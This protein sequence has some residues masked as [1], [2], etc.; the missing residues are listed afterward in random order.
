MAHS[1][2]P[3]RAKILE[4]L[5]E[6]RNEQG[7][8][9]FLQIPKVCKRCCQ[10]PYFKVKLLQYKKEFLCYLSLNPWVKLNFCDLLDKAPTSVKNILHLLQ[11]MECGNFNRFDYGN[12]TN[13]EVYGSPFPGG[14][15]KYG[16]DTKSYHVPQAMKSVLPI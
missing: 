14:M 3:F 7:D 5:T 2:V 1:S 8:M 4:S 16:S 11:N 13:M 12:E 15:T 6:Q 9:G 10:C